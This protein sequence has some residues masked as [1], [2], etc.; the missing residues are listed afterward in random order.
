MSSLFATLQTAANALE[1][2]ERATGVVQ[3]NVSNASTPGYVSQ[4]LTLGS[5]AFG[6]SDGWLGGVEAA[7]IRDSRNQFAEQ[8]VWDQNQALGSATAKDS[9]LSLLQSLVD[10]SGQNGIPGALSNLYSA[11]SAWSAKPDDGNAQASV[12]AAAQKVASAANT[13][14]NG[15]QRLSSQVDQQLAG[16]VDQ[17][18]ALT[19]NIAAING[20]IR[21][22]GP[23]SDPGLQAQLYSSIEQL[24]NYTTVGV[25]V[26][27]D[28]TATVLMNG[29]VP[30]VVGQT[31]NQ[32]Q[33]SYP[34]SASAIYPGAA[35][36]AHI[37]TSDGKDVTATV[38]Q[39]QSGG[40]LQFRNAT[41]PSLIGNQSRQGSLNQ[42]AQGLADRV[43]NLLTS[44]QSSAGPPAVSGIPLFSYNSS[45]P[46]N[47]AATL[48]VSSAITPSQLAAI[49]P[50]PPVVANGI[51]DQLALLADPKTAASKVNGLSYTDFYGSIAAGIGQ[52]AQQASNDKDTYTQ[53]LT[54]AQNLRSDVSGISLNEQAAKLIE[55]Q[56]DYEAS[57][58]LIIV[59]NSMADT[60]MNMIR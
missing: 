47:I 36:D 49:D 33:V 51:A 38:G 54:Q 60:L 53:L 10:V 52:Q 48:A 40:L 6:S 3:S 37:L 8:S 34:T 46:T 45:S 5:D 16:S 24:S 18:N 7:G 44:G 42:L 13:F 1:V 9:N 11:F 30:L 39:G 59:V 23:V 26:E 35:P 25:H 28:G 56:H 14:F 22:G 19:S 55:L 4:S 43:N 17:I 29:Q 15:V 31:Q 20:Q 50:G 21:N 32:L 12:I 27:S 2:F 58:T 41:V 57:A